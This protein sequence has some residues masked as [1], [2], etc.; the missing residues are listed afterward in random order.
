MFGQKCRDPC[1]VVVM[2]S[3]FCGSIGIVFHVEQCRQD[4]VQERFCLCSE[5]IC[6]FESSIEL[7]I[8]SHFGKRGSELDSRAREAEG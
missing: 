2:S 5:C 6:M 1:F 3:L 8:S 7:S 4:R